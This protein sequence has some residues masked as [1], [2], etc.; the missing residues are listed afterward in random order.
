MKWGNKN[1]IAGSVLIIRILILVGVVWII[2]AAIKAVKQHL[3]VLNQIE[4]KVDE[5]QKGMKRTQ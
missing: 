1:M 2:C 5:I 3:R 4:Q